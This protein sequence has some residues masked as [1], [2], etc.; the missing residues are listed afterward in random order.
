MGKKRQLGC[1]FGWEK[2]LECQSVQ[3][4]PRNSL[5]P[6]DVCRGSSLVARELN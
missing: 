6:L 2:M 4:F 5:T 3:D 1:A